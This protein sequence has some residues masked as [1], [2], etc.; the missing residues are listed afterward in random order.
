[1]KQIPVMCIDLAR[2]KTRALFNSSESAETNAFGSEMLNF[3]KWGW[4]SEE[5]R[6][7]IN[8]KAVL[9]TLKINNTITTVSIIKLNFYK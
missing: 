5:P 1:M 9:S 2:V 7:D 4:T 8:R 6:P 3:D